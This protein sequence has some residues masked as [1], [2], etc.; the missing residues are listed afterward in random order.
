MADFAYVAI[1]KDGKQVKGS[2]QAS[3]MN[4]VKNKLKLDGMMPV[5]I[6]SQGILTKDIQLGG[7]RVKTRD[8][9]V[10][11][12]QFT[13]ILNA[14]VT[15]VE[16]LRMMAEQTSSA[17]LKKA[18]YKT[19]ELVQQGETLADAMRKSPSVFS[20]MFVNMVE[21][22]EASGNLDICVGRMGTQFEKSAKLSGTV[23]KAMTYPIVVIVVALGVMIAMSTLVVPKFGTMFAGLGAE[24]PATTKL[25]M[26][27]SDFL[28]HKWYILLGV[29]VAVAAL[30]MWA[31]TTDAGKIIFGTI[32]LKL[33]V[34]GSLNA[35]SYSA[36]FARTMGTLVASGM[37]ITAAIEITAKTM[38]N[39]LFKNALLNAKTEV[40]QGVPLSVPIRKSGV[41]PPLVY[42]MLAIGEETGAIEPM[43]DKVAD[44]YEEETEIATASMSELIQ[45]IVILLIGG[46]IGLLVLSIYQPM[47]DMYGNLGSI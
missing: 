6:K 44:Y 16:A 28:L 1:N 8:L 41:F 3:D 18:L 24:L 40:E 37:G 13:S 47:I 20:E 14:G 27:F 17:T 36:K 26:G 22:G 29:V 5:S 33:P 31:R 11:C 9:S 4:A 45:P 7:G 42:N 25:V 19:K 32:A 46:I 23:K 30:I 39:V 38:K 21:A 43:L 15:V 35:K 10:F 2:M 12:R 34:F